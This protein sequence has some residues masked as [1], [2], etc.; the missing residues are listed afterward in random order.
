MR[1]TFRLCGIRNAENYYST[2][3]E[4]E[5]EMLIKFNSAVA[6]DRTPRKG[7]QLTVRS[8]GTCKDLLVY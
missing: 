8:I 6:S 2:P 3:D 1:Y 4:L 7:F 5:N